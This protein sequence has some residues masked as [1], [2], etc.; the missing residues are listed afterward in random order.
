MALRRLKFVHQSARSRRH[1]VPARAAAQ[2]VQG[3]RRQQNLFA[4]GDVDFALC[5]LCVEAGGRPESEVPATA[6][7]ATSTL[8]STRSTASTCSTNVPAIH[9]ARAGRPSAGRGCVPPRG[10]MPPRAA[11]L[12]AGGAWSSTVQGWHASGELPRSTAR[13]RS[14][15]CGRRASRAPVA[16]GRRAVRRRPAPDDGAPQARREGRRPGRVE[17]KARPALEAGGVGVGERPGIGLGDDL[18]AGIHALW[19]R[20][21][22]LCKRGARVREFH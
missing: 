18:R 6:S 10:R 13:A 7:A 8:A 19:P 2:P 17:V 1:A 14:A 11:G 3:V 20:S 22:W 21:P 4:G 12:P 15:Q 9:C 16:D 5:R